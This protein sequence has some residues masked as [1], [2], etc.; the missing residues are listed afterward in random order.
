MVTLLEK[1]E[2]EKSYQIPSKSLFTLKKLMYF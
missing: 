2:L 1:V